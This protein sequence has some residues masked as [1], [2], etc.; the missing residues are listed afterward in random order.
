MQVLQFF[1]V[2]GLAREA[3]GAFFGGKTSGFAGGEGLA[4]GGRHEAGTEPERLRA[5]FVEFDVKASGD[6]IKAAF[7]LVKGGS[8]QGEFKLTDGGVHSGED[9]KRPEL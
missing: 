6:L 5:G 8:Q 3:A 7:E 9:T 1:G 4:V 2:A